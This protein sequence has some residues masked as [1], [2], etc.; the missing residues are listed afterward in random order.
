MHYQSALNAGFF[1]YLFGGE[2]I[3]GCSCGLK[4]RAIRRIPAST[5]N[6]NGQNK[7][8][9]KKSRLAVSLS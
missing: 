8:E 6:G 3:R 2:G 1:E 9:R 4:N 5:V 7:D